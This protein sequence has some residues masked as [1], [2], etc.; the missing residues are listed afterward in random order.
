MSIRNLDWSPLDRHSDPVH[1]DPDVVAAAQKRYA[2]IATT[3]DDATAKLQQIVSTNSDSLA[4]QYVQGLK[5]EASSLNDRL[6][7]AAVR[8]HDVANEIGKYEPD[9]D[10]GLSETAAALTDAEAAKTAQ[11]KA[12]GMPDPQKSSDGTTTPRSSRRAT[13]RT[14]PSPMR[15]R[16]CRRRRRGSTTRWTRSTW[17]ASA[18][19]TRSAPGDTTTG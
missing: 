15:T 4:G 2:H 3:I 6:T 1:A 14:R 11:T 10:Q 7:K 19:A 5:S 8:Y 12:N 16:T 18:S 13:T 17:P 9:L